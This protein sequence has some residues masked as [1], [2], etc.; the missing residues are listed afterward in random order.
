MGSNPS[1]LMAGFGLE[2]E[3][4]VSPERINLQRTA[5]GVVPERMEFP[6][7]ITMKVSKKD[8]S[9]LN[10]TSELPL[11]DCKNTTT[12]PVWLFWLPDVLHVDHKDLSP[13]EVAQPDLGP[14][15]D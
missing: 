5:T 8:P 14:Q 7:P 10:S 1:M 13:L 3:M 4:P 9:K 11:R 2:P 12:R 15:E 6:N